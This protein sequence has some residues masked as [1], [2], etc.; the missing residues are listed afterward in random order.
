MQPI[1]VRDLLFLVYIDV[2]DFTS[3]NI[4][5]H[6]YLELHLTLSE[7]N[8]FVTNFAF[9]TDLLKPHATPLTAKI[10]TSVTRFLLMLSLHSLALHQQISLFGTIALSYLHFFIDD[11][12]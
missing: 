2:L 4:I 9:L 11:S 5:F 10:C 6:K 12:S 8:I 1:G 3:A 7:K